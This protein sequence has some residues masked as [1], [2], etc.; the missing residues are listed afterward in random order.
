MSNAE[1]VFVL[2]GCASGIGRHMADVLVSRGHKVFATDI[3]VDALT[4]HVRSRAWSADRMRACRL[5]VR[6][7]EGWD[8]V[9]RQ[10]VDAFGRLDVLMNIAGYLRP[11]HVHETSSD[12]VHRQIDVNAKGVIFG[13]QA[14]ARY[15]V[16]Q[17]HGHI[18]NVG[19]F[20]SL[21]PIPGIAVYCASKYAVRGFSLAAAQ[22]L[23]PFGVYV[24]LVCPEVVQ[25]PMLDLQKNYSESAV[26]FSAPR[27]LSVE[28]V[29]DVIVY[30]VLPR[31]P[32]EVF[33]PRARGRLVRLLDFFPRLTGIA[34]P[35]LRRRG[36]ARQRQVREARQ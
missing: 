3:D 17:R 8:E 30:R 5:D 14:A 32:L 19:S 11:G 12:E 31:K 15:M 2:T 20:S 33:V 36:L 13:T 34:W 10:A 9:I 29:A 6:D 23:R 35:I 24:S 27:F 25:T 18:I 4:Q 26:V 21:A 22:E 16:R 28:D 1:T 7:V